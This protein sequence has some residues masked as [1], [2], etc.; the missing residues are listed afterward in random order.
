MWLGQW[1]RCDDDIRAVC[2][3]LVSQ[4]TAHNSLQQRSTNSGPWTHTA[5]DIQKKNTKNMI[6]EIIC[7]VNYSCYSCH[8]NQN[9]KYLTYLL[10]ST[11]VIQIWEFDNLHMTQCAKIIVGFLTNV[12][13]VFYPTFTNV[14]LFSPRFFTFFN[15]FYFHLNVYYIYGLQNT[16]EPWKQRVKRYTSTIQTSLGDKGSN[17]PWARQPESWS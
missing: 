16:D 8:F 14:F 3:V 13:N 10:K 7:L 4:M 11:E 12:G 15:V 1:R 2:R 5:H 17:V 9:A 6:Y